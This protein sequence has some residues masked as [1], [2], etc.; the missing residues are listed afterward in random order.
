MT[1]YRWND[2]GVVRL[3]DRL[4]PQAIGEEL[5]RLGKAHGDVRPHYV[6]DAAR[7]NPSHPA[8]SYFVWDDAVAGERYRIDQARALIRAVRVI[9]VD[10]EDRSLRAYMSVHDRGGTSYRTLAQVLSSKSMRERLMEQAERDL[11]A[12]MR[13]YRELKD[14]VDLVKPAHDA[15]VAR[16]AA[17]AGPSASAV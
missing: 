17:A 10:D 4:D 5:E 12:W 2:E 7:D 1:Q 16:R 9:D 6:V 15:L 11:Q 13:R 14:I 8:Y 3:H